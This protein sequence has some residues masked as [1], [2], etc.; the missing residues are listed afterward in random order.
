MRGHF[1]VK[2]R[3]ISLVEVMIALVL[4]I[5]ILMTLTFFYYHVTKIEIEAD[6]TEANNFK[7]RYIET[8]LGSIIT[9]AVPKS[10]SD[11]LFFSIRDEGVT[12]PGSQSLIFI[13]DNAVSLDKAFANHILARIYLD[14]DG[15]MMAA[16]WPSPKRWKENEKLPIKKEVLLQ[17]VENLTFEFYIAPAAKER[18]S[19]PKDAKTEN[20]QEQ[21]EERGTAEPEPKGAWRKDLWHQDYR[22][23]PVMVR[24]VV[25]LEKL[26]EPLVFVYPL[27]NTRS[28]IVYE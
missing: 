3:H 10:R 7:M 23:L 8:R 26:D 20:N 14:G 6:R 22:Q 17:G 24:V 9:R 4:T 15:N 16:Y 11:F 13:F 12:K 18:N 19:L 28:H 2:K 5:G 1:L 25:K 21:P 27:I